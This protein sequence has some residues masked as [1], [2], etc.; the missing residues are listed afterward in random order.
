[1]IIGKY[2]YDYWKTF[3]KY[4]LGVYAY[5][6]PLPLNIIEVSK[7]ERWYIV[8]KKNILWI[9]KMKWSKTSLSHYFEIDSSNNLKSIFP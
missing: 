2:T 7:E 9:K 3:A 4:N 5:S 6:N 8:Y 1:M